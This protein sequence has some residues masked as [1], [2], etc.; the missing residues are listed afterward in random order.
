MR[1]YPPPI[2][3]ADGPQA[4]GVSLLIVATV[5]STI[6]SFLIPYARHFRAL[7][8]RVDA[9]ARGGSG[10]PV[11]LEEFDQVHEIPLSRSVLDLGSLVRGER[12]VSETLNSRPDIV[13]VHTP[14][15]GFLTRIAAHRTSAAP[16]P[17]VAYTAHGFHFHRGGHPTTN[18]L[19][20]TAERL[21]GRWTD[22]LV[23]INDEDFEAARRH[24]IVGTRRL[25]R[26]PGIGLDTAAYSRS[27][28]DPEEITD[29]RQAL[30]LPRDAPYF[31]VVAELS[32]RKRNADVIEALSH[33]SH[34]EAALVLL[35]QGAERERLEDLARERGV[36]DRV[37]FGGF[38][39][40]VRPVVAGAAALL[41]A[42]DREGLA[43]A[44]MEALALEVPVI[45]STARGNAELVDSESGVIVPTGDVIGFAAAMD[46]M[47]DRPR[48]HQHMGA[49]GRARM[50]ERYDIGHLLLL[51]ERMY[52]GMLA[53][54]RRETA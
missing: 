50:V 31:V 30:S 32:R 48:D 45:A 26:M 2:A 27:R 18:G 33:M 43:R 14:I 38:V 13:H 7:G 41:L 28:L 36:G 42:S 20:L 3:L 5:S 49:H 34:R 54:R 22:R 15:A 39:E 44:I 8:W 53:E 35:G 19:F 17:V 12:A 51:H 11:L 4:T 16:R 29:A 47:L 52:A 21:A 1:R 6:R 37:R 40:D 10:D 46:R 25:V 23:V 24:H 9:A